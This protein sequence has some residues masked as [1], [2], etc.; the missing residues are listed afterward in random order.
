MIWVEL[1][2]H[3]LMSI[4]AHAPDLIGI[5]TAAVSGSVGK[6]RDV[7]PRS[8]GVAITLFKLKPLGFI[9]IADK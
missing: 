9:R 2:T 4:V 1:G 7:T 5:C 3:K 6:R 8:N